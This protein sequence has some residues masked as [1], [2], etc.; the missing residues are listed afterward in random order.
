M[1]VEEHFERRRILQQQRTNDYHAQKSAEQREEHLSKRSV[2]FPS[3][4]LTMCMLLKPSEER[5][6]C[7]SRHR[8]IQRL[9]ERD[10]RATGT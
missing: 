6:A 10:R 4:T 3:A 1:S 2:N 5:E 9:R 8:G 7:L